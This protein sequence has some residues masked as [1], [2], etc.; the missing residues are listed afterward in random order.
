MK[1]LFNK[2]VETT[3][4]QPQLQSQPSKQVL[5][6]VNDMLDDDPNIQDILKVSDNGTWSRFNVID[7]DNKI[8]FKLVIKAGSDFSL[9]TKY[10]F[11]PSQEE[12]EYLG[13][14]QRVFAVKGESILATARVRPQPKQEPAKDLQEDSEYLEF[15]RFKAMKA[16]SAPATKAKSTV[17]KPT[18]TVENDDIPF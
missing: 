8:M 12:N 10:N 9:E 4:A 15:L 14:P 3:P 7:W 13:Y 6:S 1:N 2:A 16:N 11:S 18:A 17:R 5:K